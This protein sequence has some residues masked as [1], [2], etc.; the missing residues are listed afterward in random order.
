IAEAIRRRSRFGTSFSIVAVAEGAVS[1]KDGKAYAAAAGRKQRAKGQLERRRAAMALI[2]LDARHSGNTM[3]LSRE[4][5]QL[6]G[7]E[8]RVT[9]LGYVQR[10]GAPSA[11]DRL[12]ATQLGTHCVELLE[13]RE[14]GM[15]VAVQGGVTVP[16][17]IRDVAGKVKLIPA[18]HPWLESARRVSTCLGV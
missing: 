3:R 16:V 7:L 12:L 5:E 9:I 18:D 10:G 1:A 15:M 14:F 4:L 8:A 6:T 2:R 11:T 13:Q 17:P